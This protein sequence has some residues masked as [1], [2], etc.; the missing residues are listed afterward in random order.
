M[1]VYKRFSNKQEMQVMK[2]RFYFLAPGL[3][4]AQWPVI[5]SR[6][7]KGTFAKPRSTAPSSGL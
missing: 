2:D 6:V 7:C 1:G 4:P 3:K 5:R